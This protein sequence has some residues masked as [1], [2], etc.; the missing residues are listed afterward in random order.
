[1]SDDQGYNPSMEDPPSQQQRDDDKAPSTD[2]GG[3]GG[4]GDAPRQHD[5]QSST[6]GEDY[7]SDTMGTAIR[8]VFLGN[9][10]PGYTADDIMAMF[11]NPLTPPGSEPGTFRPI[12]IDRLDQKRGY[13]FVFLKDAVVQEDKENAQRFVAAISG[14]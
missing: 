2:G 10:K 6:N 11:H 7:A 12:P 13:C 14:M 9:L 8:P 1:M 3:G 5:Q 4:G